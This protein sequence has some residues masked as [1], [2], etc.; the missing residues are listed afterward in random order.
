MFRDKKMGSLMGSLEAE[1]R[2]EVGIVGPD[3][4]E[5]WDEK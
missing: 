4:L 3:I 2:S 1:M 5:V